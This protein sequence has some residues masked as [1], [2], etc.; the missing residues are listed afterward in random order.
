MHRSASTTRASDEFFL[1]MSPQ[2]KASPGLKRAEIDQLPTYDPL[3]DFS[4]KEASRLRA[5]ENAVHFI[6]L[7][8]I[9]CA[10][11]L[12]FFSSPVNM[13][14]KGDPIVARVTGLTPDRYT[15]HTA[16][17]KSEENR[18]SDKRGQVEDKEAVRSSNS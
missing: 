17:R 12:W 8:L 10:V 11:V 7:V 18:G 14:N 1:N 15:N 9:L 5:S 3:S 4:K 2:M 6:P 16:L 13:A